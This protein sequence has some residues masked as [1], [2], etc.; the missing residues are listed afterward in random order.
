MAAKAYRVQRSDHQGVVRRAFGGRV[1]SWSPWRTMAS[2]PT[3]EEA[4]TEYERWKG[5]GLSRWR[6][7]HGKEVK[8][9]SL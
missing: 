2:K 3:L 7:I 4:E 8:L 9:Q 6:V 1:N 5:K